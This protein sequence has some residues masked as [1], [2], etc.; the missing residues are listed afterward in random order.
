MTYH[1]ACNKSN[2]M[3][4]TGG[5][6]TSYPAGEHPVFNWVR[7]AQSFFPYSVLWIIVCQF[8]L[9]PLACLFFFDFGFSLSNL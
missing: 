6:G 2:T 5:A 4:A 8:V 1:K 7:V 9:W 3:S